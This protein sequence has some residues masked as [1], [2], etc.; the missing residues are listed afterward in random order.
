MF[1]CLL[2]LLCTLH[3]NLE[4]QGKVNIGWE[5]TVFLKYTLCG[6]LQPV[7]FLVFR[8]SLMLT[9]KFLTP[10]CVPSQRNCSLT[11]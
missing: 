2:L 8:L 9:L 11:L 7:I 5:I 3:R 6:I 10:I 1:Q 4:G